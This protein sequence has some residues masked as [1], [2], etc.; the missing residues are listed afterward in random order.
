MNDLQ[1]I[2]AEDMFFYRAGMR[3]V[4]LVTAVATAAA[5]ATATAA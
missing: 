1:L 4:Q 3:L 2:S 5:T